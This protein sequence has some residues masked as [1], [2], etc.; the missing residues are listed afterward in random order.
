MK[1]A[2]EEQKRKRIEER[3]QETKSLYDKDK[4]LKN[5]RKNVKIRGITPI[6]SGKLANLKVRQR[7]LIY[8][9][10][11]PQAECREEFLRRKQ[12]FGKFG[13]ITS[14]VTKRDSAYITYQRVLDAEI[15]IKTMHGR[16]T[17][18]G[19][20]LRCAVGTTKYCSFFLR[21]K[22]CPNSGCLYL[23]ELVKQDETINDFKILRNFNSFNQNISKSF[24]IKQKF[25]KQDRFIQQSRICKT[26]NMTSKKI[27]HRSWN[28]TIN[29][30]STCYSSFLTPNS[31]LTEVEDQFL[32]PP[33]LLFPPN[34]N[35]PKENINI[36][37]KPDIPTNFNNL[38]NKF[39]FYKNI[40]SFKFENLKKNIFVLTDPK[41]LIL[42]KNSKKKKEKLDLNVALE[43]LLTNMY[44]DITLAYLAA[45]TFTTNNILHC[46]P[47]RKISRFSFSL[48]QKT[49]EIKI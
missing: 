22:E 17:S 30:L 47:Y 21:R 20:A 48:Y 23:H 40:K 1:Q 29:K 12:M 46:L 34:F 18:D 38:N 31:V 49:S 28:K 35:F 44:P 2:I 32:N 6:I 45:N 42:L 3:K 19:R 11:I 33:K 9:T 43:N 15:A 41:E 7:N 14:C 8:V 24:S 36:K 25:V 37:S 13:R 26:R 5:F 27:K 39:L 4:Y 10:N 16:F